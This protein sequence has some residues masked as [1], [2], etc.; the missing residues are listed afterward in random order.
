MD[1]FPDWTWTVTIERFQLGRA[2]TEERGAGGFIN[3][4]PNDGGKVSRWA[5]SVSVTPRT[6][7]KQNVL[8]R[9]GKSPAL[10]VPRNRPP[11]HGETAA[12]ESPANAGVSR[13]SEAVP[14]WHLAVREFLVRIPTRGQP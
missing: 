8:R 6:D 5:A 9:T 11:F 7:C 4:K 3:M 14:T 13:S 10:G 1:G 2:Q 12:L